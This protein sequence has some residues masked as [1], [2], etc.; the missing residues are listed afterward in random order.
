ML[1]SID[2]IPYD[3]GNTR[4]HSALQYAKDNFFSSGNG[5]RTHAAQI[6]VVITDGQSEKP[7]ITATKAKKLRDKVKETLIAK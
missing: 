1:S 6:A 5:M 7:T 3:R 2:S 4:T